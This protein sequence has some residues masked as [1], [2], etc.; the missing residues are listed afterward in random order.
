MDHLVK[1][2]GTYFNLEH[3]THACVATT[4]VTLH[5]VSGGNTLFTDADAVV[6]TDYLDTESA[7]IAA[8]AAELAE[9]KQA[10]AKTKAASKSHT[11]HTTHKS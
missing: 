8:D 10:A 1:L 4:G 9:K 3:V 5:F 2:G 11:T 6:V 7:D